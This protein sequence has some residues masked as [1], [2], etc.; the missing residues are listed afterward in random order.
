MNITWDADKY[1]SD[2]SFVGRY[3]RDLFGLIKGGKT[4]LDL[5]CGNGVLTAALRE[6]GY[7]AFGMEPSAEQLDIA[8]RQYPEIRFVQ[9]DATDFELEEPVD[10]V[11]ANAVF[12]WIDRENQPDMMRCVFRALNP[13]GQLIF[14]MGGAGNNVLI[15]GALK[16]EFTS[17]GLVY[18][19]PFYFP[20]IAEYSGLL[21]AAGFRV[22]FAHLFDRP[23]ELKGPD[24]L[25]DWMKMFVRN[26]FIGI[27]EATHESILDA[28]VERLRS[29]LYVGG[30]W[31][32]DYVRLRMKA[33]R[34]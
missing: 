19:M 24:G 1:A 5:G 25:K 28:T 7:D 30:K 13:G 18:K 11:F 3:G 4:V 16:E 12:H 20:G 2:F 8:R 33:L 17:R 32:S 29:S 22:V 14:E 23:T 9:G 31:Y 26:P 27:D 15:H 10:V 34:P 6:A 21:E